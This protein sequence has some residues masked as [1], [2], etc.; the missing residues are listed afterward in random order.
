MLLRRFTDF[1]LQSRLQAMLV[2]FLAAFIPVFGSIIS[3]V[4]AAFVT[5]RKG[6]KEGA[7][8]AVAAT[9]PYILSYVAYSVSTHTSFAV[10]A[11]VVLIVS[12][13]LT[14]FFAAF[15]RRYN[16]WGSLLE[17]AAL[18]G[19]IAIVV[20][21]LIFPDIQDWWQA[22]LNAYFSYA[23]KTAALVNDVTP[24]AEVTAAQM[25]LV[26]GMK[27]YATGFAFAF[28]LLHVF[29]QLYLAR[30]WQA[31]LFNRG[32]L[33][34]ELY[35]IRLSYVAGVV[36]AICLV[37]AYLGSGVARDTVLILNLIFFIAGLSLLH[38]L[39]AQPRDSWVLIALVY[40]VII[41]LF[42]I[43]IIIVALIG[44]L[45]TAVKVRQRIKRTL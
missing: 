17:I 1:I 9:L 27:Q 3:I 39:V 28:I 43:S 38:Y 13:I 16:H 32:G 10:V 36:F 26:D 19:V 15:L 8:I 22:Q 21:H 34:P 44:L 25:H 31:A 33:R 12:N 23:A 6:I 40:V 45:D 4:I 7:L 14:W 2:A 24:D 42:P 18:I 11:I 29:V 30:W 37:L 41:G 20:L 5:L 35:Q